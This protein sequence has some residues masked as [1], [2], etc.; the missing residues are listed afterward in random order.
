[1]LLGDPGQLVRINTYNNKQ[2]YQGNEL[3]YRSHTTDFA[4]R[5]C[6]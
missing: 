3:L 1:M 5:I 2:F 6:S 4:L